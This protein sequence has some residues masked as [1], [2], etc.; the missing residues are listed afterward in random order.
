M[1]LVDMVSVILVDMVSVMLVDMV[2]VILVDMA[3]LVSTRE[4]FPVVDQVWAQVRIDMRNFA[5]IDISWVHL[6]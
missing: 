5:D 4:V 3:S 6:Q 2:S 1:M